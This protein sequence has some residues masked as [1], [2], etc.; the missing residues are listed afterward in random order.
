VSLRHRYGYAA[1]LPRSLPGSFCIPP[2]ELPTAVTGDRCA[3]LPAQIRQVSSRCRFKGRKD[4]GSSRTPLRHARRTRPIWQCWTRPGFVRAAPTLTGTTRI[5]LPPA[6]PP[7]CDETA[8]KVSHLHSNQQ[9]LTAQT[10]CATELNARDR[11]VSSTV[12]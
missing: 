10:E 12:P 5:R 11:A 3:P 6:S 7:R 4:A 2:K 9:H 8:A 1:D